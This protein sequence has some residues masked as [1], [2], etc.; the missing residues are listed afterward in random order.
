MPADDS[1]GYPIMKGLYATPWGDAIKES[2]IKFDGWVTAA[3]NWSTAKNSNAPASYWIVPNHY[4]LDQLVFRSS[5]SRTRCRPTTS[6]GVSAPVGLY[7]IDYRYT[8]AGGWF[9]DQLLEHNL[10]YGLDPRNSTSTCTSPASS[11]APIVRVGRWIAC[12]DIETQF[13]PDNYMGSHSHPVHLR[14][15]HANR[16]HGHA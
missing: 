8:T 3:G 5:A 9:S 15:L 4:E 10:L 14:H 13:A 7:G 6:T 1:T 11:A 16:R 12:P 2:G